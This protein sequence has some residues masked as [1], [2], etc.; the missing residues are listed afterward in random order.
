MASGIAHRLFVSGLTHIVMSEKEL[1]ISVRRK[2]SFCEAVYEKEMVVEGVK[3]ELVSR[4]SDLPAVWRRGSIAVIVDPEGAS[5]RDLKPDVLVDA[6]MA[7]T[8][9]EPIKGIATLTIGVGPGFHAPD[10]V[11]AV[12]E[13]NRGH[14]LG[15]VFY[16]GEAEPYTGV[17]GLTAGYTRERVLRA[18]HGGT[19]RYLCA[20]GDTVKKGDTVLYVDDT[21]VAS[22][23]DGVLRGL[24]RPIA[25][26]ADEK[27]GD[28]DP[29]AKPEHCHTISEKAR[30][31]A[32]GV[33]EAI[34]HRF[35]TDTAQ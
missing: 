15:R 17:P 23:I 20:L 24:I 33:L 29:R 9:K 11:D 27:L 18:P 4:V 3:A 34:M 35:N 12:I 1:P 5:F 19:V 32:G 6:V 25:V 10:D 28:V 22:A 8:K 13:S 7:K 16:E 30:A 31:I 2:V 26:P 14:N 21:P